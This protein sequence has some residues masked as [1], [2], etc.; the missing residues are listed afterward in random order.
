VISRTTITVLKY[1]DG[2]DDDISW[3]G[4]VC[5]V[6]LTVS[7]RLAVAVRDVRLNCPYVTAHQV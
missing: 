6:A 5:C 2:N 7:L 4:D 3:R 1:D